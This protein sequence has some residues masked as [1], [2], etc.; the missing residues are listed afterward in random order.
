MTLTHS[1]HSLVLITCQVPILCTLRKSTLTMTLRTEQGTEAQR[2]YQSFPGHTVKKQ[3]AGCKSTQPEG[4]QT[5]PQRQR[6]GSKRRPAGL[7]EEEVEYSFRLPRL[8]RTLGHVDALAR[9]R[10]ACLGLSPAACQGGEVRTLFH[11]PAGTRNEQED[12]A[13]RNISGEILGELQ[14]SLTNLFKAIM[15]HQVLEIQSKTPSLPSSSLQ[16]EELDHV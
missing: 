11:R 9:N 8:S 1:G 2:S 6:T 15:M 10:S 12:T 4:F 13:E 3:E 7:M 14:V 5:P 16:S